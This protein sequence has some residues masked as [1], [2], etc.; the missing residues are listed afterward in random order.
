M[1]IYFLMTALINLALMLTLAK[2]ILKDQV[3]IN[4]IFSVRQ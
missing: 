4:F 3:S 2:L 1:S